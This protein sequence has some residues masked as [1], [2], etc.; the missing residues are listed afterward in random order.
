MS[1]GPQLRAP[2][3]SGEL[4]REEL[5]SLIRT[6]SLEKE[7]DC[8]LLDDLISRYIRDYGVQVAGAAEAR[9]RFSEGCGGGAP[10]KRGKSKSA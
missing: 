1:D 9:E 4:S 7:I 5:E 8:G 10:C 2:E 6:V 3:E